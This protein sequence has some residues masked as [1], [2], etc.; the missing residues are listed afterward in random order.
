VVASLNEF[1]TTMT[2]W[3]RECG[4]FVDKFI[5]D[6]LMAVFGAP[7]TQPDHAARA[8]AAAEDYIARL[9]RA[10]LASAEENKRKTVMDGDIETARAKLTSHV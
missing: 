2:V 8:V 10:A 6:C 3:V 1:F 4:G 5:G 9:A 7:Q